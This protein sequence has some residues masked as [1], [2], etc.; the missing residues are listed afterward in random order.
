VDPEEPTV[1]YAAGKRLFQ[2]LYATYSQWV[3]DDCPQHAAA[4]SYY[5]ALSI[6]P[7]AIVLLSLGGVILQAAGWAQDVRPELLDLIGRQTAPELTDELAVVIQS[8]RA[9]A[10]TSGPIGF[11]LLVLAAMAV[12]TQLERAFDRIWNLPPSQSKGLI[13]TV[14]NILVE[15]LRAFL[16]LLG[17]GLFV[18]VSFVGGM[19][20]TMAQAVL[21]RL[22]LPPLSWNLAT[23][24]VA[25]AVNWLLLTV[26]Y[27]VLAVAASGAYSYVDIDLATK[28]RGAA[29]VNFGDG[30]G[31]MLLLRW[32]G[33]RGHDAEDDSEVYV[34]AGREKPVTYAGEH[35]TETGSVAATVFD[36]DSRT[37]MR[38][39]KQ[40]HGACYYREP[41]GYRERVKVTK[42]SDS[43][44]SMPRST[45][46]TLD[47][48]VVE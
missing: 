44:G 7:L 27:R 3:R 46:I 20:L 36:D 39:L 17:I 12:F 30:F 22:P 10:A 11:A 48:L 16:M 4:V 24:A 38:A 42:V 8:A 45:E 23:V 15:R 34:F 28:S 43:L 35:T 33:E 40:W 25:V 14:R 21:T 19:A 13:A 31:E 37:A 18:A 5:A 41:Y 29:V 9:G 32:S 6:F 47:L 1:P 2:S 26:T